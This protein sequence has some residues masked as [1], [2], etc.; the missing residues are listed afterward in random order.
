MKRIP[1]GTLIST[2]VVST[3]PISVATLNGSGTSEERSV[4]RPGGLS[5]PDALGAQRRGGLCPDVSR[6]LTRLAS[7]GDERK[8]PG[9]DP[10]HVLLTHSIHCTCRVLE[11]AGHRGAFHLLDRR[12]QR[13][14]RAAAM[15]ARECTGAVPAITGSYCDC[16]LR[17]AAGG[18]PNSRL[19]A[20]LKA[21]SVS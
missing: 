15:Q 14:R 6:P 12:S 2:S 19:N 4:G 5:A 8:P 21:A 7:A 18:A 17:H 16:A 20:R 3:R 11:T 13:V 10:L 9:R 1:N